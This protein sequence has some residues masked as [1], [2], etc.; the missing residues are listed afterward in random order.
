[1][2]ATRAPV[3]GAGCYGQGQDWLTGVRGQG[4]VVSRG[5]REAP[6]AARNIRLPR[7][8]PAPIN[9]TL[10]FP[11]SGWKRAHISDRVPHRVCKR[12][13]ARSRVRNPCRRSKSHCSC[14]PRVLRGHGFVF[15]HASRFSPGVLVSTGREL[16]AG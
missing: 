5:R 16:T 6:R 2:N 14:W 12:G 10:G 1:M 9:R 3:D 7:F 15:Q 11:Q 13:A 4:I 8:P